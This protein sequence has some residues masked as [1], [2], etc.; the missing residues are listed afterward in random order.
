MN[1]DPNLVVSVED[2]A[3]EYIDEV[4]NL[5]AQNGVV[6]KEGNP[7]QLAKLAGSPLWLMALADGQNITEW[8]ERLRNAYNAI[9]ITNCEDSQVENLAVLAGVIKREGSAPYI[10]LRVTNT[11]NNSITINSV[12][13]I[14]TD[15]LTQNE[16]YSGQNYELTVGETADLAFYCRQRSV[17]VPRDILFILHNTTESSWTDLSAVSVSAS[18]MLEAP[19]SLAQLRNRIIMR[20]NRYDIISL[21]ETAISGLDG[22]SK[23]SIWFNKNQ[24]APITLP[25]GIVLPARTAYICIQGYDAENL[26]A[27]TFFSY[28]IVNTLQTAESLSSQVLIGADYHT[29]Y[30]D[31]CKSQIAYIKV[32]VRPI[33]GDTTYIK[34]IKDTL[35]S[36]SG[37]LKVGENLTAQMVCEWLGQ[38]DEY[39]T[40]YTAYVGTSADPSGDVTAIPVNSLLQF[41]EDNITFEVVN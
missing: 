23:C 41:T 14:A 32:K 10:I 5:L 8:Q 22:I 12:N 3:S 28:A 21:A 19:E 17:E 2:N 40:I 9:S 31:Q 4:N 34:R 30:Y 39:C 35:L 27:R 38:L 6:D 37:T 1:Y 25:G 7:A 13:C 16:W 11:T 29:V 33:L 26:I 24:N 15:T 20:R 18:R 36:Y